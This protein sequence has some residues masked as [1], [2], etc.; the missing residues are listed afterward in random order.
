[1]SDVNACAIRGTNIKGRG[2]EWADCSPTISSLRWLGP[3]DRNTLWVAGQSGGLTT[4][5][6]SRWPA[7]P[8]PAGHT[9]VSYL[10]RGERAGPAPAFQGLQDS[11]PFGASVWRKRLA[12]ELQV[13]GAI[14]LPHLFPVVA[15]Y[16]R[17]A[18][19]ARHPGGARAWLGGLAPL[20][21][22]ARGITALDPDGARPAVRALPQPGAT[23]RWPDIDTDFCIERPQRG[24]RVCGRERYWRGQGWAQ[25]ITFT[26]LTS[27]AVL[28]MWPGCSHSLWR[29]RTRLAKLILWLRGKPPAREMIGPDST[30][31]G[32]Q[33]RKYEKRSVVQR[34]AWIWPAGSR[35]SQQ[36]FGNVHAAGVVDCAERSMNWCAC[37]ATT[38]GHGNHPILHGRPW[39]RWGLLRRMDFLW[40][41]A[42]STMIE[43]NHLI[44]LEQ[45]TGERN[46]ILIPS[47]F[48]EPLSL[49]RPRRSRRYLPAR[50]RA[51][52]R[53][54]VRDL[55]ASSLEE[56]LCRSWRSVSAR[57]ARLP[58]CIPSS[59]TQAR[60]FEAN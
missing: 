48:D 46:S 23:S 49:A 19:G 4:P 34:L 18:R 47:G 22:Y 54:I 55:Q 9:A 45:N 38:T 11:D 2:G 15:D 58:A 8:I 31:R 7:F 20:V 27:K 14:G 53:Q 29:C 43:K 44:S 42:T 26:A 56:H 41:A 12:F 30:G 52:L 35:G 16:I 1:V 17:Y 3:G 25:I 51:A 24:D 39:R 37:S 33:R 6:V 57:S 28:R 10:R 36:T 32:I 21:A 13:D 60:P 59:S 40:S 5:G 50:D